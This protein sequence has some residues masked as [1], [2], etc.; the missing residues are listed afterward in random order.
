[1]KKSIIF[2]FLIFLVSQSLVQGQDKIPANTTVTYIANEGFLIKSSKSKILVDALF[3]G[4]KGNWCEQPSDSVLNLMTK[5]LLPFDGVNVILV[6]HYHAD[7]FNEK[8]VSDFLQN[9]PKA[10]LVCPNQVNVLLKNNPAYNSYLN[11]VISIQFL[12]NID[13][14]L[15]IGEIKIRALRLNHGSY[16]EKDTITGEVKDLHE[17]VE[18]VAYKF[19]INNCTVLHSGDA[20]IMSF[21]KNKSSIVTTDTVDIAFMD[22]IFLKPE[23]MKIIADVVKP[24]K[25]IFMHIEP[26]RV[27]YYKSI[28]KD[29]ADM[30][31]FSDAMETKY[32][33]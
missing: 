27:E 33:K 15:L 32:F 6:S 4:I 3:G 26:A 20:S 10:I 16:F 2:I 12:N 30:I 14:T 5:G 25:L 18:N 1:M 19:K 7:H 21:E 9:N 17:D 22:R 28:I 29:F 24:D 31:I 8:M 23:G 13:T 11:R